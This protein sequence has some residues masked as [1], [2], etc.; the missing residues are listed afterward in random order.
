M[1]V[2]VVGSLRVDV[3]MVSCGCEQV[4]CSY[5]SLLCS[6]PNLRDLFVSVDGTCV[7]WSS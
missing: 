1:C 6:M 7:I 2:C 4:L 5:K 3:C